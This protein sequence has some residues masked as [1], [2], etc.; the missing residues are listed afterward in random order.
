[1]RASI[2]RARASYDL[3]LLDVDNGPEALIHQ[4]NAGLYDAS[5]IVACHVA[6]KDRGALAV[7]ATAS[8]ERYLRRLE[9]SG[10]QASAVRVRR[11]PGAGGRQHVV[12]VAVKTAPAVHVRR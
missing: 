10:F 5:G 8:D 3:I 7:W 9:R 12:F 11:R 6:L 2:A 4:A 1:M